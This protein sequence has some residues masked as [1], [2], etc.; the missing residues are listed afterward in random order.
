MYACQREDGE[1]VVV[2]AEDEAGA[3]SQTG[4][5]VVSPIRYAVRG[6]GEAFF[7]EKGDFSFP[8]DRDSACPGDETIG[9]MAEDLVDRMRAKQGGQMIEPGHENV[10]EI[11]KMHLGMAY[12]KVAERRLPRSKKRLQL[13]D[14]YEAEIDGEIVRVGCQEFSVEKLRELL[15][16]ADN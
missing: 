1:I 10:A 15:N 3:K 9:L 2:L 14:K 6:W 11:I 4:T 7:G 13:N 12:D 5:D 16:L 8:I